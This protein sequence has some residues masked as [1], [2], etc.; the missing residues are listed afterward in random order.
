MKIILDGIVESLNTRVDGSV[1]IVF[2]TQELDS[3]KGGELFQ[4]RGKYCKA[5][6]SD[7]NISKLEEEI[8]DKT[9][10]AQT[11]KQKTASQR[12]RSVLYVKWQQSQSVIKFED[13][14]KTE[15]EMIIEN[16]KSILI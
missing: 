5:L 12:L 13:Y 6:L 3:G 11:G 9:E 10:M 14:Y 16:I 8:V 15:M 7:N 4:L 1:K 2:S